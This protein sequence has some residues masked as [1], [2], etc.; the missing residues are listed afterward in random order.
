[1]Q[2]Q[3]STSLKCKIERSRWLDA[4]RNGAKPKPKMPAVHR[5]EKKVKT[6]HFASHSCLIR[7]DQSLLLNFSWACRDWGLSGILTESMS[8]YNSTIHLMSMDKA[9]IDH[10]IHVNKDWHDK[11][12]SVHIELLPTVPLA[13]LP[14]LINPISLSSLVNNWKYILI[15]CSCVI[16]LECSMLWQ[17]KNKIKSRRET[18]RNRQLM[19]VKSTSF[20]VLKISYICI[21][22]CM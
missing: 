6:F 5:P 18:L 22:E 10:S 15:I 17:T 19:K 14:I 20:V 4:T 13:L 12:M 7:S 11:F 2:Q 21:V 9:N 1:M 8:I 16:S 3:E